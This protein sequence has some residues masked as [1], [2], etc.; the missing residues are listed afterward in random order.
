M[1]TYTPAQVFSRAQLGIEAPL[2]SVEVHIGGGLPR[3][4]IVGLPETAVRESKD[5]VRAALLNSNF[6]FPPG[7]ITVNLAPADLPKEGGRFDLPIA[8]GILLATRQI[9]SDSALEHELIGELGLMGDVRRV[10]G[11]LPAAIESRNAKRSLVVAEDDAPEASIVSGATILTTRHLLD[12]C[13][14]LGGAQALDR[15]EAQETIDQVSH[16][17][18]REVKGQHHARRALEVAAAGA[19]NL[20]MTGPPGTGKTMLANRL[21]GIL[22]ELCEREA[23]E[24]AAIRSV[25]ALPFDLDSWRRRPFRAPHHTASGVA[26]VGGGSRP[27][28]GEI[29]LAHNGILFLDELPEYDRR[30]LEVLREPLESRVVTISRAATQVSYPARFQLVAAMNPCPCGWMG[31]PSGRCCCSQEAVQRYR[32]R[33]SGPFLDRIDVQVEVPALK[34]KYLH[35]DGTVGESSEIV[36]R[37]V[38]QAHDRQY[39]RTGKLNCDLTP[40]EKGLST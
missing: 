33:V 4:T 24:T 7:R 27:R 17:D 12:V 21:P 6:N 5:R 26:L 8:I 20:L 29:S 25:S 32:A 19:H 3:F 34:P 36:R 11:V 14:H 23:I 40:R 13:R 28:P 35:N 22:P 16:G 39:H 2:V 31:D 37:R 18:L 15:A 1:Q 38:K 30:V 10:H 9:E